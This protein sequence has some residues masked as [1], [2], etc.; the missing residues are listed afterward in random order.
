MSPPV[1]ITTLA[2]D[3]VVLGAAVSIAGVVLKS[4]SSKCR[5]DLPTP[6]EAALGSSQNYV[7]E[8]DDLI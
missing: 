6:I 3:V 1:S 7:G 4:L 2:S 8:D 5:N